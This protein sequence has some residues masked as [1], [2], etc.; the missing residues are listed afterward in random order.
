MVVKRKTNVKRRGKKLQGKSK[1]K[2]RLE[3]DINGY[4]KILCFLGSFWGMWY[5]LFILVLAFVGFSTSLMLSFVLTDKMVFMNIWFLTL[6]V[7]T[8]GA[9]ILIGMIILVSIFKFNLK[10]KLRRCR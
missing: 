10:R 7:F 4:T 1:K 3:N 6:R 5:N 9:G 8:S 2:I